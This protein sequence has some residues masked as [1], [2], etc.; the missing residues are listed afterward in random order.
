MN[1]EG[2][3]VSLAAVMVTVDGG[4]VAVVA[5]GEVWVGDCGGEGLSEGG[6]EG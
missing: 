6:R 4:C 2:K 3:T 1:W 5:V